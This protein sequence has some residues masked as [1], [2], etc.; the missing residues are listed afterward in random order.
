MTKSN[1]NVIKKVSE[2]F[3]KLEDTKL[4]CKLSILECMNFIKH[5]QDRNKLNKLSNCVTSCLETIEVCDLCQYFIASKSSNNV[6]CINFTI[7]VLKSCI[8]K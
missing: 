3:E 7:Q 6:K 1:S 8:D 5:T 2:L 4:C